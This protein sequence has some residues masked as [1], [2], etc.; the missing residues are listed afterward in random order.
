MLGVCTQ[1]YCIPVEIFS[2]KGGKSKYKLSKNLTWDIF[3]LNV[4][5]QDRIFKHEFTNQSFT[6]L[7]SQLIF[8]FNNLSNMSDSESYE[9]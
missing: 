7:K 5:N 2:F 4:V 8:Y 9:E 1:L 6:R 3:K